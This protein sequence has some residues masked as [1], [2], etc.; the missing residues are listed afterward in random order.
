MFFYESATSKGPILVQ[1]TVGQ[2]GSAR[3]ESERV[4]MRLCVLY[5]S[6]VCELS[7]F[8]GRPAERLLYVSF[9]CEV[10]LWVGQLYYAAYTYYY[11]L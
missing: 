4:H 3:R 1:Y 8:L 11:C 5:V 7:A 2:G 10:C 6:F 9:V